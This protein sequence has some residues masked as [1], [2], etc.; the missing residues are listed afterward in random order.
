MHKVFRVTVVLAAFIAI[1]GIMRFAVHRE[2]PVLTPVAMDQTVPPIQFDWDHPLD[3]NLQIGQIDLWGDAAQPGGYFIRH[4]GVFPAARLD[5]TATKNGEWITEIIGKEAYSRAQTIGV[6][7]PGSRSWSAEIPADTEI[8]LKTWAPAGTVPDAR[9]TWRLTLGPAIGWPLHVVEGNAVR[10]LPLIDYPGSPGQHQDYAFGLPVW[11]LGS[12]G[13]YV[14]QNVPPSGT[15][16][17]RLVASGAAAGWRIRVKQQGRLV[18]DM[19]PDHPALTVGPGG[20][21]LKVQGRPGTDLS[22]LVVDAARS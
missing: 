3:K 21:L 7:A 10:L 8:L 20:L 12:A 13:G 19:T 16:V 9:A 14:I 22:G 1:A 18:G 15:G 5:L 2:R 4:L 17:R 6:L 11:T